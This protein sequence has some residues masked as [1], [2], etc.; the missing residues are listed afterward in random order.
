[1]TD[2]RVSVPPGRPY[3]GFWRRVGAW[4]IDGIIILAVFYIIGSF[5]WSDLIAQTTTVTQTANET[6][7]NIT[8][9]PSLIGGIVLGIA[10]WAYKTLQESSRAQATL[11]KRALGI[12]VTG[13]GGDRVSLLTATFRSWPVWLPGI[14]GA[15]EFLSA[16]VFLA[17]L[18]TCIAVAFTRQKQ[19]LHDMMAKC[20]VVRH[21]ADFAAPETS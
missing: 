18:A 13:L 2:I 21:N 12:K 11:G 5:L 14:V 15:V 8:L 3:G 9:A 16:I 20:L 4:I 17:A 7:Y 1:M 10:T 19:G 6:V